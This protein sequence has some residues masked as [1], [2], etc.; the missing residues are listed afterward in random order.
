MHTGS[1]SIGLPHIGAKASIK[2]L[3]APTDATAS[4][5][6]KRGIMEDF[7]PTSSDKLK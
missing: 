5:I 3:L 6:Y 1:A 4:T 7:R 2:R